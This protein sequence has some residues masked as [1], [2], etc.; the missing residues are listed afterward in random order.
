MQIKSLVIASVAV[1]AVSAQ[2]ANNEC[3]Q[4]VFG[5]FKTD[6]TCSTLTPE[7]YTNLTQ[8]FAN[9]T[10]NVPVL[11]T[12]IKTPAY[13]NCLCHWSQTAFAADG[14]GA[15][16]SCIGGAAPVCNSSQIAE[17]TGQLTLMKPALHCDT[18]VKPNG[19]SPSPTTSTTSPTPSGN[20][21]AANINMPYALTIAA[22][23]LVALAGF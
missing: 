17:A 2:F 1:A 19:T 13:Q 10:V 23:G 11:S 7:Q 12:L 15:A 14:S 20:K 18:A 5:S 3:T 9:N 22:F 6:S 21:S 4:C 16:A 8:V